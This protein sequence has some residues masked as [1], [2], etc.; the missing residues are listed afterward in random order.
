[1]GEKIDMDTHML[2]GNYATLDHKGGRYRDSKANKG[3]YSRVQEGGQRKGTL[4]KLFTLHQRF[5]H[6]NHR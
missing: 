1:V 5:P 4:A 2:G 3:A 6:H